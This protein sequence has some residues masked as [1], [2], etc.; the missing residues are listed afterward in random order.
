MKKT[1]KMLT[2]LSAA[3]LAAVLLIAGCEGPVGPQGE[4]G[5]PGT[6]GADGK[7]GEDGTPGTDGEQ[8]G[9][10]APAAPGTGG[11][12]GYPVFNSGYFDDDSW[13]LLFTNSDK[14][15]LLTGVEGIVGTIPEG[16]TL[17]IAGKVPV[18]SS[19]G[20]LTI[21][22]TVDI[23]AKGNLTNGHGGVGINPYIIEGGSLRVVGKIY[24]TSALFNASGTGP[25]EGVTIDP[26]TG[27]VD[28]A[29]SVGTSDV[30]KAFLVLNSVEWPKDTLATADITPLTNWTGAKRLIL[31]GE[32]GAAALSGA[33]DVSPSG[34]G[35]LEIACELDL[36]AYTLT[37]S[38]AG[39]GNITVTEAGSINLSNVAGTLVGKIGVNGAINVSAG[40][41]T[42]AIP[43]EVDLTAAT[44]TSG[45]D[46]AILT[47]PNAARSIGTID[48]ANNFEIAGPTVDSALSVV[49]VKNSAAKTLTLP[50]VTVSVERFEIDGT[51]ALSIAGKSASMTLAAA[52]NKTV[53]VTGAGG[54]TLGD[55]LAV[56]TGTPV[57]NIAS[58]S[59]VTATA[60][61]PFGTV[62]DLA[63]KV[64]GAG[65]VDLTAVALP[66][67]TA[68][69]FG[70][71]ITTSGGV[72]LTA[73]ATF[74]QGLSASVTNADAGADITLTL[75]G[76]DSILTALTSVATSDAH[77][78]I[79]A[80]TGNVTV[81]GAVTATKNL[82]VTNTGTVSFP[83]P[84]TVN[85]IA[86][87]KYLEVGSSSSV[88][89]GTFLTFGPGKYTASGT[90]SF[91][92]GA[93]TLKSTTSNNDALILGDADGAKLTLGNG[94][95]A[96]TNTFIASGAVV[97]LSGTGMGSITVSASGVL[98]FGATG[99]M[100]L[101][102]GTVALGSTGRLTLVAGSIISGFSD[103][104]NTTVNTGTGITAGFTGTGYTSGV[105]VPVTGV[106]L[107]AGV[108]TGSG[109]GGSFVGT[110]P[111][112]GILA[113]GSA[114]GK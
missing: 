109:E 61:T 48:L 71:H 9:S 40:I 18:G 62:A 21:K 78:L 59:N 32:D 45:N 69:T 28:M 33:L 47:L 4:S 68:L 31:T 35:K 29:D 101:G 12:L 57:I 11:G 7:P 99:K 14:V 91:S 24:Y 38:D 19:P 72:T 110:S 80:G 53:A 56:G 36:G 50:P 73:N 77:A 25:A 114:I 74:N 102:D 15:Q 43:A 70:P 2:M 85:I 41:T 88:K 66:I 98:A 106:G 92:Y 44:L 23:L 112:G 60:L 111:A 103:T 105:D 95:T 49:T 79:L 22:G 39:T 55:N 67:G 104:D 96:N 16:K 84:D 46:S 58:G 51:S 52:P 75:N 87:G 27:T 82:R 5:T 86:T 20:T 81:S 37:G 1:V 6:P 90:T 3:L 34:K 42:A 89:A 97:T 17:E 54:L 8:G 93:D 10:G 113:K 64:S 30:N 13:A 76:A 107:L 94:A 63:A 108:I 26:Q 83:G 65:T 100:V